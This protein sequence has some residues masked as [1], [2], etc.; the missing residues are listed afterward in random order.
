VRILLCALLA[1]LALTGCA[2]GKDAVARGG[3]FQFVAPGGKDVITYDPPSARGVLR[4]FGGESLTEPGRQI[5]IQDYPGKVVVINIWGSWCGPCRAEMADLQ[6]VSQQQAAQG[7]VVLGLN[8]RD[9]RE[10]AA[11]FAR[12]TG[13][14]YPS[15]YD[16]PGR[17]LFVLSGYPRNVV[18]STILLDRE[19]RVAEVFL[20]RVRPGELTEAVRRLAA[21]PAPS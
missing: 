18:P 16:P 7:V 4:T 10:A 2:T 12:N 1:A 15:I 21:E 11:D 9:S 3:D 14:T 19:H 6:L 8:Q 17:A 13:A 20:R 5:G